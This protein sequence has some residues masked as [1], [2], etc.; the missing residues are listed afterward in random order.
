MA[1]SRNLR[2]DGERIGQ[3]LDQLQAGGDRRSYQSVQELLS[4]LSGLYE[5]GISRMVEL[6]RERSPGLLDEMAEDGL[7][8]GLLLI[9]GLHPKSLVDR[10]E[11]ALAKV[12]PLLGTHGGDVEIVDVDSGT[13][14][15][16]IRL[17][18]SCDGCP[19]SAVTLQ[20]A[21]ERAIVDAAPE[22]T[23]IDVVE[24]P[25]PPPIAPTSPGSVP[26]SITAKRTFGQCPAEA[27][28]S[29]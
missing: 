24:P 21:V 9:H 4:L 22:I 10:L 3:L 14:A 25:P 17:L 5:V 7:V 1:S 26:V 2:A 18:G 29:A 13:G 19:S 20:S 27:L 28:A 23:V 16:L 15:V 8:S 11:A 12:R 6:I